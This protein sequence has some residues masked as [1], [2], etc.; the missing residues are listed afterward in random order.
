MRQT[1]SPECDDVISSAMPFEIDALGE[2]TLMAHHCPTRGTMK[3][4][5][6]HAASVH[7]IGF[8]FL[9]DSSLQNEIS[10]MP[11]SNGFI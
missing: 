10:A 3:E 5:S 9:R 2:K 11:K 6:N 7:V 4:A 1:G 8:M